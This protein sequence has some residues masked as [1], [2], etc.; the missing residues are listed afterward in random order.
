[1]LF[2]SK[3]LK[4]IS[5][6]AFKILVKIAAFFFPQSSCGSMALLWGAL[7]C[8]SGAHNW[9]SKQNE[10]KGLRQPWCSH[11]LK[12]EASWIVDWKTAGELNARMVLDGNVLDK[13]NQIISM[14]K[15]R[16]MFTKGWCQLG[17]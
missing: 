5:G 6:V 3:C 15:A 9:V 10:D 2:Y 8:Q 16:E 11:L 1:M 4:L 17:S 13:K 14:D 7:Q 12:V